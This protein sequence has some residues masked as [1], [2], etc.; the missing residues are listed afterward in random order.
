MNTGPKNYKLD[1]GFRF[2]NV[3]LTFKCGYKI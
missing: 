2:N 3:T 1:F